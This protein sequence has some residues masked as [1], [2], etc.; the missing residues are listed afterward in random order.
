MQSKHLHLFVALGNLH[1]I[2]SKCIYN[3]QATQSRLLGELKTEITNVVHRKKCISSANIFRNLYNQGACYRTTTSTTNE[4]STNKK[5][6][7]ATE[8]SLTVNL[9]YSSL[10]C[11]FVNDYYLFAFTGIIPVFNLCLCMCSVLLMVP[12]MFGLWEHMQQVKGM[13]LETYLII[14]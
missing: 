4:N 7:I 6:S 5:L 1:L 9:N 10:I 12:D 11:R 13:K 14:F 2:Y 8:K 3:R